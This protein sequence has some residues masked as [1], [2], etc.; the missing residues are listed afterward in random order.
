[1]TEE[2]KKGAITSLKLLRELLSAHSVS[3]ARLTPGNDPD[4]RY[5]IGDLASDGSIRVQ[6]AGDRSGGFVELRLTSPRGGRVTF[7]PAVPDGYNPFHEGAT[8]HFVGRD[9]AVANKRWHFGSRK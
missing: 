7:H 9:A 6:R 8:L 5:I 3:K 4:E 1:M 2:T